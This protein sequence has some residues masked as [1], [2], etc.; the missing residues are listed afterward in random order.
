MHGSTVREDGRVLV[1][2]RCGFAGN[3]DDARYCGICGTSLYNYCEN[4]DCPVGVNAP[5]RL[6]CRECGCLTAYWRV[7][8]QQAAMKVYTEFHK[9][10]LTA[11]E[12]LLH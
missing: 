10:S 9:P 1:C 5:W 7:M 6:Y 2:L 12:D 4:D 8:D 3:E 11:F